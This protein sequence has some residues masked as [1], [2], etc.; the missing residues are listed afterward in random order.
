MKA[1]NVVRCRG[2]SI[3]Q[4]LQAEEILLRRTKQNWFIM[5]TGMADLSIVLGFGG[6]ILELIDV[7][8][9]NQSVANGK[10]INVI[11]RYTGGGTV[12]VDENTVFASFIMNDSDVPTMPYP[13][14]IMDWS[15]DIYKPVFNPLDTNNGNDIMTTHSH[16]FALRENDYILNDLKIGG[17]AQTITKGRWVHHTSFLWDYDVNN[18]HYLLLPKK[19]PEYRKDRLHH[20]FLDKIYHHIHTKDEFENKIIYEISKN[21]KINDIKQDY[22]LNLVDKLISNNSDYGDRPPDIRT[23][24]VEL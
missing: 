10:S 16:K 3:L 9:V 5:N 15:E 22:M 24:I 6:K 8:K 20:E 18:M 13:R 17:N 11:R 4:Q 2:I 19:Q 12:I 23:R 1:I 7:D 14:D 21:Y